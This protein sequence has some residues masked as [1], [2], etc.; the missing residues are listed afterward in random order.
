[1]D[2][3][4]YGLTR[5]EFAQKND[6]PYK[7]NVNS[8]RDGA[9]W[10]RNFFKKYNLSLR[11]PQKKRIM[12]F[13]KI[14]VEKFYNILTKRSN[15]NLN[16]LRTKLEASGRT[17]IIQLKNVDRD[18]FTNKAEII[19]VIGGF[20]EEL[21]RSELPIPP[22]VKE[23]NRNKVTN[24]NSEEMPDITAEEIRSALNQLKNGRSTVEDR[25]TNEMLKFGGDVLIRADTPENYAIT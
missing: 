17:K 2:Q 7:F 5:N 12:G 18:T 8:K 19:R 3:G 11:T 6:I 21:S 20:Y 10:T 25:I 1:M 4:F 16:I 15:K 13:N 14:Q 22:D 9:D 23:Q 24:V